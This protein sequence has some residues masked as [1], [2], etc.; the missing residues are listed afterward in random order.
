MESVMYARLKSQYQNNR[1]SKEKL[2]KCATVFFSFEMITEAEYDE[3][4]KLMEEQN[5]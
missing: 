1:I 3:L 2:T 5:V 4:L